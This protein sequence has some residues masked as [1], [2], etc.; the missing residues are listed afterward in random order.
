[1][2]ATTNSRVV[3]VKTAGAAARALWLYTEGALLEVSTQG[4]IFGHSGAS[5]AFSIAAADVANAHGGPFTGGATNPPE[6]FS[7]DGPRRMFFDP[8][9]TP[10]TPG[11]FLITTNGGAIVKKPDFTAADGVSTGLA[12]FTPFFG[13]SAAAPHFAAIAA[14]VKQASPS[15]TPAQ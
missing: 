8:G 9:G 14:L 10:F 5:G 15:I 11:N 12:S 1:G 13:T 7:S 4:A 3:I 6:S 2:V